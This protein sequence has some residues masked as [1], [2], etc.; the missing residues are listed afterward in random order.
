V[1]FLLGDVEQ[2][3]FDDAAFSIVVS[4]LS[5]HHFERPNKVLAEM[6]RVCRPGGAVAIVDL[7]APDD[8]KR[9][10]A[11]NSVERLRDPSHARALSLKEL[12]ELFREVDLPAPDV[13]EYDLALEL[14]SWLARSFPDPASVDEI[15]R[16]FVASLETD[17]LGVAAHRD[18]AALHFRYRVAI[19]VSRRTG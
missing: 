17:D 11:M 10:E 6:R 14:E 4:R 16:R 2:L 7:L 18:G 3:P 9:A 8:P 13:T 15:R 1:R 19:C 5:V 12:T